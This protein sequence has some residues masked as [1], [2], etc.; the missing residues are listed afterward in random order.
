MKY[1]LFF[2]PFQPYPTG[3]GS[4]MRA[5]ITLEALTAHYR[6]IVIHP[7]LWAVRAGIFQE[8]WVRARAA[9]YLRIRPDR[10]AGIGSLVQDFLSGLQP[11][12]EI[13]AVFAF[14]Q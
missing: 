11:A 14:R 12:A 1:C 3:G 2:T 4:A 8:E 7:E 13:D 10:L 9:A 5:S 6:V